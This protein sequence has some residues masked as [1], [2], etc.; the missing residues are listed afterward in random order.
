MQPE[1]RI[2]Q[3]VYNILL[4]RGA[5]AG[6]GSLRALRPGRTFARD[7]LDVGADLSTVRKLMGHAIA[8]TA[9]RYVRRGE[10]AMRNAVQKL[11]GPITRRYTR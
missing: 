9:A 5:Q 11:Q 4:E 10:R 1:G 6:V 2:E 8:N 7:L 3:G